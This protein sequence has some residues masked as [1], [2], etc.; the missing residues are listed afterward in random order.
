MNKIFKQIFCLIP[1][2]FLGKIALS[3][4]LIECSFGKIISDENSETA[5]RYTLGASQII[6]NKLG[7]YI[8]QEKKGGFMPFTTNK[9][10]NLY[11]RHIMGL[12]YTYNN[13]WGLYAGLGINFSS[14]MNN[15]N[16]LITSRKEVGIQYRFSNMSFIRFGYSKNVGATINFGLQFPI[17]NTKI[18]VH[19][20]LLL[21]LE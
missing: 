14:K 9:Y 15:L 3:Q 12:Q 5:V 2:I 11:R 8:T 13:H 6:K 17:S 16:S 7:F 21:E 18:T 19:N 4:P 10:S 20:A 1:L